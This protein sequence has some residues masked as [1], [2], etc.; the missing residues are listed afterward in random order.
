MDRPAA[1][2]T[3]LAGTAGA[4]APGAS[5][6]PRARRR[7]A[8]FCR[9]ALLATLLCA[10]A[11]GARAADTL[12]IGSKAF[13][14]NRILAQLMGQLIEARTDIPVRMADGL[15]GTLIVFAALREGEIDLYPEYTG[16]GWAVV[17]ERSD[18][19]TDPLRTYL[20]VAREYE[21]RFDI[22]WLR[23]FGF[24]NSYALAVRT[25]VAERLGL[26][27]VSDLLPVAGELR[28]GVSHEFLSRDDG[29]PGM[30]AAYGLAIGDLRGMEHGLAFEAIASGQLDL[31]DAWT[32]DGKLLRY[33]VRLLEDDLH[34]WPPYD[35]APIV[36]ADALERFPELADVLD[37]LAFRLPAERMQQLNHRVEVEGVSFR[38]AAREFLLAEGLLDA[39]RDPA[40]T[41]FA[42]GE[43]R[44]DLLAFV[45]G[46]L[47][48]TLELAGEHLALTLAAVLAAVLLAVPL[49]VLLTRAPR[50]AAPV[51]GLAGVV[52]T[53]PSL[54][55]LA[56]MLPL[57]GLGVASALAALFLYALLPILRNTYTGIHG[58][59]PTL[60]DAARGMGLSPL[61]VLTRVELPLATR[62]I[63]AGIRTATVIS[64]GVATLA[65][66]V[67][68]GGLGE[69]IVTGLQLNDTRLVMSGALP[70]ALLAIVVDQLLE[71]VE[72]RLTRRGGVSS[73]AT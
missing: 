43:R 6:A 33:D 61:Q 10:L 25:P 32:T 48:E 16:T 24:S 12:V 62:T 11:G 40:A 13:A 37:L 41:G 7:R 21:R 51:L 65:A 60:V 35:C 53:V 15:G 45:R 2:V 1:I 36:R 30:A 18:A 29:W 3:R 68:A 63:M 38:D 64:I 69:P 27:R 52:Q 72:R 71:R 42:A 22:R 57:L 23:P 54:A 28:A 70:A 49:G 20:T 4:R 44:G 50:L 34:F 5:W 17:L 66:F 55:L 46:R 19:A 56:F 9:G 26:K 59:D 58:V 47:T 39:Q 67:G 73:P 31:I 14:E 8:A